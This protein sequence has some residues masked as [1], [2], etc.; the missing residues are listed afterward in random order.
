MRIRLLTPPPPPTSKKR[1]PLSKILAMGLL[2]LI[3]STVMAG[4]WVANCA[5]TWQNYTSGLVF[6]KGS[7]L[8]E[9]EDMVAGGIAAAGA[10]G[11]RV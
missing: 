2:N 6:Q 4:V 1:T 11:R 7:N 10:A 8:I 5:S 3:K 9:T